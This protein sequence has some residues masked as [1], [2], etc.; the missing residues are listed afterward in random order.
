MK[1]PPASP[2][3]D[4]PSRTPADGACAAPAAAGPQ[5]CA[6]APAAPAGPP[7]RPGRP[8]RPAP[9]APPAPASASTL[10]NRLLARTRMRQLQL[11]V[12]T[13]ELGNTRRAAREVG[14][15]ATSATKAIAELEA[16][17]QAPLF[18]RHARGM[19]PTPVCREMLPLLHAALRALAGCAEALAG[20]A[21]GLRGAVR[22]GAITSAVTGWLGPALPA[23]AA[24]YPE[25]RVELLEDALPELQARFAGGELDALCLRR[26][27]RLPAGCRWVPLLADR[28]VVVAGAA[29][30]LLR[31]RTRPAAWA[32]LWREP[33]VG[34]PP[35]SAMRDTLDALAS[36]AGAAPRVALVTRSLPA[37]LG[38][39]A[40]SRA[41]ALVPES[42]AR[43]F[44]AAGMVGI[45]PVEAGGALEPIGL[46]V[47]EPAASP[48]LDRFCAFL[49]EFRPEGAAPAHA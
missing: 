39:L 37:T 34:A 1:L 17:L 14:M 8:G 32:D 13:A 33:W 20:P 42:F 44:A 46:L 11:V 15:G 16:M 38:F 28:P 36:A 27:G 6:A 5:A 29:H 35:G 21:D 40:G 43:A 9:V 4:L 24:R 49:E 31:R 41:C 45:L 25:I 12:L 26:S 2:V 22:V 47:A 48:A 19:R 23:F 10:L 30:P 7:S 3:P 18:E